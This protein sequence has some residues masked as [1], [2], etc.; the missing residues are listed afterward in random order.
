MSGGGNGSRK[1]DDYWK[2]TGCVTFIWTTYTAPRSS[3][4]QIMK[5]TS[6]LVPDRG[7]LLAIGN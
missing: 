3:G 6:D 4:G 2:I 7:P 1:V 5:V